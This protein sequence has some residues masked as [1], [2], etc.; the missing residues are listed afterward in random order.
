[1]PSTRPATTATEPTP[2]QDADGL[3]GWSLHELDGGGEAFV[4]SCQRVRA[5]FPA[6]DTGPA[7][8]TVA[9]ATSTGEVVWQARF[10]DSVPDEMIG[11]LLQAAARDVA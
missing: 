1:M 6:A 9:A 2:E 7:A 5:Y 11:A 3:D 10:D 4:S 8:V